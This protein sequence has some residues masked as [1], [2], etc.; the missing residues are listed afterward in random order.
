MSEL[1]I[2][3]IGHSNHPLGTFVWLLKTHV[4]EALVDVR[5]YPSSR[6]HP[7]FSRENLSVALKE[8]GI[9][10]H[11][12]EALGGNRMRRK[13][14]PASPNRGIDDEAFRNYADYMST[15]EFRQGV[16]TLLEIA[17]SHRT[18]IMCAE[19]DYRNCHRR[20]LSDYLTATGI[21]VQHI[22]PNGDVELH[23]LT[24]T[25]KM[26]DGTVTYPGQ[27]TLFDM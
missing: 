1:Q 16:T 26:V 10:Y 12:L 13:D 15:N 21:T 24:A 11:W 27:P 22:F 23:S 25:A 7:H 19:G 6:R 8:E 3:T 18:V 9:E 17:R 20:L 4:I 5:R 2:F 14:S